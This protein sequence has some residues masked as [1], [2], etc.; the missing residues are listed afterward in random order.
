MADTIGTVSQPAGGHNPAA[1]G[2][3]GK[4]SHEEKK[5]LFSS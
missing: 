1:E 4:V 5:A 2:K 3:L